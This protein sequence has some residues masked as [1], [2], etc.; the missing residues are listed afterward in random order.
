MTVVT[1]GRAGTP[2]RGGATRRRGQG[3]LTV[4]PD[5]LRR[6]ARGRAG[7]TTGGTGCVSGSAPGTAPGMGPRAGVG[8]APLRLTPRGR[9]LVRVLAGVGAAAALLLVVLAGSLLAGGTADAGTSPGAPVPVTDHVVLPGETLW[10]IAE[11]WAPDQ[12]PR[13]VIDTIVDLNALPGVDIRAGQT[14]ALPG[15]H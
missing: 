7:G 6:P 4:V 9:R 3:H 13:E 14:L 10:S 12:D 15:R 8:P 2:A 11:A 1:V 5:P